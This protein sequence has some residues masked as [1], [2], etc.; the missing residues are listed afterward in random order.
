MTSRIFTIVILFN[1]IISAVL[2]GQI[3]P[4]FDKI[5][6]LHV[7]KNEIYKIGTEA[8]LYKLKIK[9]LVMEEGSQL[10]VS[11]STDSLVLVVKKSKI[12]KDVI[13]KM[14]GKKGPDGLDHPIYTG[15]ARDCN[16]GEPGSPGRKGG[17]GTDAKN[18][19]LSICFQELENLQIYAYGGNGGAGG[20]G[21]NGQSG[22]N[23]RCGAH[24]CKAGGGGKG[25]KAGKGGNAGDGGNIFLE[26]R[27]GKKVDSDSKIIVKNKA[28]T[29]GI[30]GNRGPGGHAGHRHR[31]VNCGNGAGPGPVGDQHR[32][33]KKGVHGTLNIKQKGKKEVIVITR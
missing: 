5:K 1:F 31:G 21:Q 14:R 12:G 18:L 32:H 28:G 4:G 24:R 17:H 25:G 15:R 30:R 23:N 29:R 10:I 16:T 22:G 9:R 13:L 7:K 27:A 6:H 2:M 20:A 26:Y 3:R 33:G 19:H 8:S 11:E